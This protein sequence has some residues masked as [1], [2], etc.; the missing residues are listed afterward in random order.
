MISAQK[1]MT[2]WKPLLDNNTTFLENIIT[3][4]HQIRIARLR[5]IKHKVDG[6]GFEVEFENFRTLAVNVTGNGDIGQ[7]GRD[8]GYELVYCYADKMQNEVLS[9]S[10]TIYSAIT[11]VSVIARKF[12]G[13]GHAGAAGFSFPRHTTPFPLSANVNWDKHINKP[14]K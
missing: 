1:M 12:G 2:L 10:V 8:C 13:G 3:A 4:G 6:S 14:K 9:T 11:D 5:G 7:Y